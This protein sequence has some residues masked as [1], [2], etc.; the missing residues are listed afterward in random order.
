[1][2]HPEEACHLELE[3]YSLFGHIITVKLFDLILLNNDF[4]N[5]FGARL[6]KF[7]QQNS[8]LSLKLSVQWQSTQGW[9]EC[10]MF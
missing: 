10:N 6:V 5:C 7:S 1:M 2:R 4:F 8:I 9:L 3:K